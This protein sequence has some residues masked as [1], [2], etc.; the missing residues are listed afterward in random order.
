MVADVAVE[1]DASAGGATNANAAGADVEAQEGAGVRRAVVVAH[2]EVVAAAPRLRI[3]APA[4][5]R[6]WP[7]ALPAG[8]A[9][10]APLC[11]S[12][13]VERKTFG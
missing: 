6:G 10:Q 7:T 4:W 3:A 9:S 8:W 1:A 11:P 2:L 12:R 13:P 5:P